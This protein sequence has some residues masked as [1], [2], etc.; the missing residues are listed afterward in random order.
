MSLTEELQ[1]LSDMKQAG[2][3]SE[4]EYQAAKQQILTKP[5]ITFDENTWGLFIHLSQFLTYV[6]PL[7]GIIAPIILW[8]I[9]KDESK[10]I[11]WHGK[12]VMNWL[13][14]E[15]I[16]LLIFIPMCIVLIGIPFVALAGL[17]GIIFPIIGAIKAGNGQIWP[18]PFSIRF[19]K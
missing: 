3:I 6:L 10:I 9:K 11:D 1:K 2:S 16:F 18:Y 13:L 19:F 17:A 15:F 14:T 4:Q 12:I 7:A 5:P 8:Q